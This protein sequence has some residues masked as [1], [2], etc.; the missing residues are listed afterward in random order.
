MA[1]A[2]S[3]L[4]VPLSPST[5]TVASLGPAS[6]STANSSRMATLVPTIAPKRSCGDGG[7]TGAGPALIRI[8][9]VPKVT[10]DPVVTT[11][12]VIRAPCHQVPLVEP[13][14]R[15]RTPSGSAV[16]SACLRDTWASVSTTSQLAWAPISTGRAPSAAVWAGSASTCSW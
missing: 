12:S 15:T 10:V 11:T 14:S 13:R 5:S 1:R 7:T 16:S 2:A 4:P 8:G 6:S 3:S 9:V